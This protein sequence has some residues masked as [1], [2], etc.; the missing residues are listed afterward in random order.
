MSD[1]FYYI[2]FVLLPVFFLGFQAT[3]LPVFF[4]LKAR[5]HA[6]FRAFIVAGSIT[7][8]AF[9]YVYANFSGS[10]LLLSSLSVTLFG[11]ISGAFWFTPLNRAEQHK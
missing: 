4:F 6:S 11:T 5:G 10:P 8:A 2:I 9:G 3:L 7:G 1:I